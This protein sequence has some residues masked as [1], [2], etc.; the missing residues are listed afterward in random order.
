MFTAKED[1]NSQTCTI[2]SLCFRN[3]K[4]DL[5]ERS[6]R[7]T[8]KARSL[9]AEILEVKQRLTEAKAR[10]MAAGKSFMEDVYILVNS[11]L[12]QFLICFVF[13]CKQ[14]RLCST[15]QPENQSEIKANPSESII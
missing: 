7:F 5:Q 14:Q 12:I 2:R 8:N 1:I 10:S 9:A 13:L 11:Y 6:E 15:H 4:S 3:L